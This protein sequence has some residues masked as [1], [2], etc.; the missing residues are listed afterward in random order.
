MNRCCFLARVFLL[1]GLLAAAPSPRAGAPAQ[2]PREVARTA[3][4][5]LRQR[6]AELPGRAS[7][8]LELPR[9]DRYAPCRSLHAFLPGNGPLRP[10]MTVG[11]RCAAPA[12]WT[13]YV[14]ASLSVR[15][16]YYVAA[17]GIGA[18]QAVRPEALAA[19]EGDLVGLP[20]GAIVDSAQAVGRIAS[21]RIAMG[22]PVR[23]GALRDAESVL[24]GRTVRVLARGAGFVASSE[25]RAMATAA[26][27]GTVQVR[28]AS[29]QIVSGVVR[30][31]G[32]VEVP[33]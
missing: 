2:D 25:G 30:D 11:V 16:R 9:M 1:S 26:P 32:T 4:A 19:R 18:G 15:G 24:R 13:V 33:L 12:A 29:G 31:A 3:E 20:P 27:G 8:A 14:Q 21:Q 17:R 23:A 6:A 10:R 28:V 7:V 5:F 22:R